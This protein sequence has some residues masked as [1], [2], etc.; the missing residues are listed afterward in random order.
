MTP[1]QTLKAEFFA[2]T[3]HVVYRPGLEGQWVENGRIIIGERA[4]PSRSITNLVHEMSHFV[5]IDDARM[6][7]FGWGLKRPQVVICGQVCNDPK[8]MQMTEREL[9]VIAY[10][11]NVL[12]FIGKPLNILY[13]V[14][15]LVYV[16]DF[17]FV[18]LEDGR[19][20]WEAEDVAYKDKEPSKIRW[21]RNRVQT[22]RAEFTL[23]RFFS[24]WD[25]K[26]T[27]LASRS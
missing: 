5:E 13:N 3:K 22:L 9:R 19:N 12:E 14:G 4:G 27:I 24:E 8:T 16:P 7:A 17:F 18:P 6:C 26:V 1:L 15:A 21:C 10:Q 23:E 20:P 25:R 11:A 2:K